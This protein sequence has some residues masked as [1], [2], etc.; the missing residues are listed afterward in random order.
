MFHIHQRKEGMSAAIFSL[1]R[2]WTIAVGF[3]AVLSFVSPLV[4]QMWLTPICLVLFIGMQFV[5][6]RMKRMHVP[7]C[8]RLYKEVSIILLVILGV[9]VVR[10]LLFKSEFELT[11]QPVDE[12]MP[13]FGV[14]IS[15]PITV[16][17]TLLFM[18]QR[19]EPLVCQMCHHRYGNVIEKGFI[20][21]LYQR[22]WRYQTRTLFLLSLL[23]SVVSWAYYML[24]Y[25]NV[26][27][28]KADYFIFLWMPLVLYVLSLIFLGRRYYSLWLYYCE[29]D[30]DELVKD[31]SSS[32]VRFI[33]LSQDK[34]LLDIR[35]IGGKFANGE[36]IR[37]FD[38]PASIKLPYQERLDKGAAADIFKR[39]AGIRADEI[40]PIYDSPD[41]I[42]FRNIF[43]YFAFLNNPE[44]IADSK[45]EGEWFS[46]G[47]LRQLIA[48]KLVAP[49]LNAELRRIY[50]VAMAWKTY[51]REGKRLY[52]IKHYRPTFRLKDI[53]QWDVDYSDGLWLEIGEHNED[54]H[55]FRLRRMFKKID[56]KLRKWMPM[57]SI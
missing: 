17:V 45:L 47:E 48:Q 43:H 24:H 36:D 23:L 16:I 2:N 15:G 57:M 30:E 29:N 1:W 25:I 7:V 12:S 20:G 50:R 46:L 55:F 11:G 19:K 3:L 53:R 4:K 22:E 37:R 6:S 14:L 9:V 31:S 5:R 40:R 13:M 18:L 28:N 21:T 10:N 32:S 34:I 42:T 35:A 56:D 44:E 38:T 41:N 52:Q 8:S 54:S 27:L 51:D 49:N 39:I 26:N 33:V